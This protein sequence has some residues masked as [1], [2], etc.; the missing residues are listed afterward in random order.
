MMRSRA[1]LSVWQD[2]LGELADQLPGERGVRTWTEIGE[3]FGAD[4]EDLER[5]LSFA[6][7]QGLEVLD[8]DPSS[9]LIRLAGSVADLR[10]AL[11]VELGLFE[12]RGR[13]H[14]STLGEAPVPKELEGV[15]EAVFGLDE[16][17]RFERPTRRN[18]KPAAGAA[19]PTYVAVDPCSIEGPYHFP[20]S[21]TGVG[22]RI[23]IVLLGGGFDPGDLDVYF[24]R[25]GLPRPEIEI[26]E[27]AGAG[28]DPVA[29]ETVLRYLAELGLVPISGAPGESISDPD[30][31]REIW[32]TI[33]ATLD[34]EL[35]GTFAPGAD[36]VVYFAPNHERGKLEALAE[37]IRAEGVTVISSSWGATEDVLREVF[38]RALDGLF[39]VAALAGKTVCYSSGDHGADPSSDGRPRVQ[40]PAS[41]PH[42][43]SCGG[44]RLDPSG[45]LPEIA[46]NESPLATGGGY[47]R[48]FARPAWQAD[49]QEKGRGLPDIAGKADLAQGYEMII[50]GAAV[51]MGGT[52]AVTPLWAGLVA[53][54]AEGLG[55]PVGWLNPLLYRE[56]ARAALQD[57]TAGD[58]GAFRAGPGWDPCTGLGSPDGEALLKALQGRGY[59]G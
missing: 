32:W 42:A 8:V 52:S 47:S 36:L 31:I 17:P 43:L 53:R 54:L 14:V 7:E 26:V 29:G 13:V 40:F 23:G 46:W 28:N 20:A 49:S 55:C 1:E 5:V 37:A 59:P 51:P 56:A 44:T 27:L 24:A 16:I 48:R 30:L 33:E 25:R 10:R 11:G 2:A 45:R 4:P 21:L 12:H 3:V 9:R 57:I 6:R 35:A 22:Q 58:N 15:V 34:V 39:Q 18:D 41:S 38:V 50:G 19:A